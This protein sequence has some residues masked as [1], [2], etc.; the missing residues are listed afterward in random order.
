MLNLFTLSPRDGGLGF[1]SSIREAL[2]QFLGFRF[3]TKSRI[4]SIIIIIVYY[5]QFI[6]CWQDV[7]ILQLKYLH[8]RSY[9]KNS[10]LI[11]VNKL[12]LIWNNV[13]ERKS[14]N[15]VVKK[16]WLTYP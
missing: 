3:I 9:T 13:K 16:F 10:M 4:E 5:Y 7:K 1:L 14:Y 11:K 2:Q 12:K 6:L 15:N 8:N